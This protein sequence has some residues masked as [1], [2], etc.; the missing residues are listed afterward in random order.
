MAEKNVM[1]EPKQ[2]ESLITNSYELLKQQHIIQ[3]IW[4]HDHTVWKPE[5][6]EITNRLGWLHSPEFMRNAIGEI[7][8]FAQQVVSEGFTHAL[9]LGM[10]GSSLAP[11]VFRGIFGVKSGFLD[12]AVLDSTTPGAV[13]AAARM[14]APEKTLFI[15]S[16]KSG[17]TIE[18][19]SF[20]KYFYN[21]TLKIVGNGTVGKH[22]IAITDPGSGLEALAKELNFRK[23][24]LNDPE[25]EAGFQRYRISDWCLLG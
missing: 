16:T 21:A 10:G 3:R 12:L 18:T 15:A 5:S 17:S 23:I 6:T 13:L 4:K 9:L 11:E 24:F 25:M 19:L 7:T 20:L 14:F 1:I 8:S 22:F 2:F